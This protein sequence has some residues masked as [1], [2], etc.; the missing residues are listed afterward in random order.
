MEGRDGRARGVYDETV[1]SVGW[2]CTVLSCTVLYV[3]FPPRAQIRFYPGKDT[4]V[5]SVTSIPRES[6]EYVQYAI[7]LFHGSCL[8]LDARCLIAGTV[9]EADG[10]GSQPPPLTD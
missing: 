5:V 3:A 8:M 4:S 9:Q 10:T 7:G 6:V 2:Y 1:K